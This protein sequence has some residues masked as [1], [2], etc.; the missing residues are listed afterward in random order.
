MIVINYIKEAKELN[1]V[2]FFSMETVRDLKAYMKIAGPNV[3]SMITEFATFDIMIII[4]GLVGVV[5]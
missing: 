1:K 4:M 2:R 5:S 3:L